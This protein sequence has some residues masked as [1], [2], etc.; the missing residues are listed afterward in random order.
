M[1]SSAAFAK[2]ERIV[3]YANTLGIKSGTKF[4]CDNLGNSSRR[5]R[6]YGT[7]IND[8]SFH[9]FTSSMIREL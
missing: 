9:S 1:A 7:A 6:P 5:T 3:V 2:C 8:K 4:I